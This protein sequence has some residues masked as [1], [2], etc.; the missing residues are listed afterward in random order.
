MSLHT[1]MGMMP[2]ADLPFDG[3]HS[4]R[5]RRA[6]SE[7]IEDL[8]AG[9]VMRDGQLA[10]ERYCRLTAEDMPGLR[11]LEGM[12][13]FF[14]AHPAVLRQFNAWFGSDAS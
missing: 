9:G 10:G 6:A 3:K 12:V 7:I 14:S 2:P 5:K 11:K 1:E 8:C 13:Q 4:G